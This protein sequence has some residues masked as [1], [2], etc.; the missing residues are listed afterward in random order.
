MKIILSILLVLL[1]SCNEKELL[2]AP[3]IQT[4]D[5]IVVFFL[6]GQKNMEFSPVFG[7]GLLTLKNSDS[8][9]TIALTTIQ[10]G[11]TKRVFVMTFMIKKMERDVV[12]FPLDCEFHYSGGIGVEF[13][14]FS[15]WL[16][17]TSI[18][19]EGN[20]YGHAQ[21]ITKYYNGSWDQRD[22]KSY[23]MDFYKIKFR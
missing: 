4:D 22:Q 17:I 21:L 15:G 20:Y 2:S 1:L 11:I 23:M 14:G 9:Y 10:N 12:Y 19:R 13:G 8:T 18:D 5:P 6:D 7:D 3:P 16:Q